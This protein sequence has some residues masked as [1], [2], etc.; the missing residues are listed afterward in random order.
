[1]LVLVNEHGPWSCDERGG[2]D[3]YRLAGGEVVEVDHLGTVRGGKGSQEG[4][5]PNRPRAVQSDYGLLRHPL[6][7]KAL[8]PPVDG[9]R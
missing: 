4:R 1:M 6:P 9:L 2:I 5:L 3:R 7:R 8:D